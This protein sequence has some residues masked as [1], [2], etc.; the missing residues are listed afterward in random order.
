MAI[1]W[2]YRNE[3]PNFSTRLLNSSEGPQSFNTISRTRMNA[4]PGGLGIHRPG[5][6]GEQNLNFGTS[7]GERAHL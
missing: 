6:G 4:K 1:V 2:V 3:H 5:S 7:G